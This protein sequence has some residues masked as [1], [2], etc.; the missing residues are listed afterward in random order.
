[1]PLPS[2]EHDLLY[3]AIIDA[4]QFLSMQLEQ[5][6]STLMAEID[7]LKTA[8]AELKAEIDSE[9]ADLAKALSDLAASAQSATD[10]ATLKTQV[11]AAAADAQ[12]QVAK[13]RSDNTAPPTP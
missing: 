10:L 11:A 8:Q 13:L 6:R 3:D 2:S 4:K 7:D 5:I 12:A 9:M 1:M